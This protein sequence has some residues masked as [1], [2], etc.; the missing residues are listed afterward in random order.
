MIKKYVE[1]TQTLMEE[2]IRN[3]VKK[4]VFMGAAT[5]LVGMR[6]IRLKGPQRLKGYLYD[7][8]SH[9]ANPK[10]MV[11]CVSMSNESA[12]LMAEKAIWG[13]FNRNWNENQTVLISLLP[14]FMIG[15]PLFKALVGSNP[16]CQ[17]IDTV[18]NSRQN[19]FPHVHLPTVDVRDVALA[20]LQAVKL[21]G[22][23]SGRYLVAQKSLWMYEIV[24]QLKAEQ[25][26]YGKKIKMRR[27]TS[28]EVMLASMLIQ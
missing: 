6:P 22:L 12:K 9:F 26:T 13:V 11:D 5:N 16:S 27:L 14:H 18:L 25:K 1:A 19:T 17:A 28:V 15:P 23:M 21:D 4:V 2:A 10:Q 7:D 3:K 20:H 8:T 24:D